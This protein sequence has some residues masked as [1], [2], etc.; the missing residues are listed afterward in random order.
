MDFV[1][2]SW[3]SQLS[4]EAAEEFIGYSF[5]LIGLIYLPFKLKNERRH[6]THALL[7]PSVNCGS[8]KMK[9]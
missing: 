9:V 7:F 2:G 4:Q 1:A 3:K 5:F 8:S 6:Y